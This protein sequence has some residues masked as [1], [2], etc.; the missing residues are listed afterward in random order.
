MKALHLFQMTLYIWTIRPREKNMFW[1]SME[2]CMKE[3]TSTLPLGHGTLDRYF[4][5]RVQKQM[6]SIYWQMKCNPFFFRNACSICCAKVFRSSSDYAYTN[7]NVWQF[8]CSSNNWNEVLSSKMRG[9]AECS[10]NRWNRYCASE[11][12]LFHWPN[13]SKNDMFL[14]LVFLQADRQHHAD[15]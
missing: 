5:R 11:G 2:Y 1:M 10:E 4:W 7:E 9:I 8:H 13:I 6:S 3:F 15:N 12:K 14:P